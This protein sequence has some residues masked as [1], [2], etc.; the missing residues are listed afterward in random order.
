M[1]RHT[2]VLLDVDLDCFTTPSDAD[3]N[4]L[5]PWPREL[6]REF[7]MPADSER[8]WDAVLEKT[9]ALTLAREP[10]HSGGMVAA[11]RLF[12]DLCHVLFKDL[13]KTDLP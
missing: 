12:E 4:T 7:L 6:I 10:Y 1:D 5:V 3:P 8:F 9:R 13:L 11:G 2:H